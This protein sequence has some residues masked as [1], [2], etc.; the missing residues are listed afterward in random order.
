[1]RNV[2]RVALESM[3][4]RKLYTNIRK[5]TTTKTM[6]E[7]YD[8]EQAYWGEQRTGHA[9]LAANAGAPAAAATSTGGI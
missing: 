5:T 1:M 2:G 6:K 4:H 7:R 9:G 8:E 3:W